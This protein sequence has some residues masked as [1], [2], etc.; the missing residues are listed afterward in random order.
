MVTISRSRSTTHYRWSCEAVVHTRRLITI[1]ALVLGA[2]STSANRHEPATPKPVLGTGTV[3]P[4]ATMT[5]KLSE[6]LCLRL[7]LGKKLV[8]DEPYARAVTDNDKLIRVTETAAAEVLPLSGHPDYPVCIAWH[9]R[10]RSE[11]D[12]ASVKD[13]DP[14]DPLDCFEMTEENSA[15]TNYV[16][17]V[18]AR[19]EAS[20]VVADRHTYSSSVSYNG[21]DTED[22]LSWKT[23]EIGPRL[24]G[25]ILEQ[26]DGAGDT[27]LNTTTWHT[28]EDGKLVT[29][30]D[31][32]HGVDAG[33]ELA[34]VEY[35]LL[36]EIVNGHYLIRFKVSV[37]DQDEGID[38][39]DAS[40][41][42]GTCTWRTPDATYD[43]GDNLL[44]Y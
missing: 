18:M 33:M 23:I 5:L 12:E 13:S 43:C 26:H 7:L 32:T 40:L 1:S 14:D 6:S 3:A 19:A 34:H 37:V 17:A 11:C 21:R 41:R 35:E 2:C 28:V 44:P 22:L 15:E 39:D 30:L 38:V 24:D 31:Y 20:W 29:H 27:D 42:E 36:P 16:V 9:E 10:A 25:L 4:A 8:D